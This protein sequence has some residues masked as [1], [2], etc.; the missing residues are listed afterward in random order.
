MDDVNTRAKMMYPSVFAG[1]A[2]GSSG[3]MSLSASP[4]SNLTRGCCAWRAGRS[5]SDC[6][7]KGK[8]MCVCSL[9]MG[10]GLRSALEAEERESTDEGEDGCMGEGEPVGV[11]SSSGEPSATDKGTLALADCTA[12]CFDNEL[13]IAC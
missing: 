10:S 3:A 11:G 4:S 9:S 13:T 5:G 8:G 1:R 6:G 7:N 12:A 2:A